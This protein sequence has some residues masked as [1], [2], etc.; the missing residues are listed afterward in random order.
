MDTP[1]CCV[2]CTLPVLFYISMLQLSAANG[3]TKSTEQ[4][5]KQVASISQ[6]NLLGISS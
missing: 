3:G 1:H 6:L 5:D 2:M 4:T